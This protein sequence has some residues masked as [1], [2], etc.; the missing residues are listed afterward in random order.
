MSRRWGG[1]ESQRLVALTLATYGTMCH[2]CRQPG[3]TT[4]DH[5]V[6]RSRG[7]TDSL[8]NLR[9]AHLACNSARQDLPLSEWFRRHP[10]VDAAAVAP[11]SR[12]WL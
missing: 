8:D 12:E 10:P 11:P 9:P 4:A 7:G 5:L 2:L 6:P 1:R 3:A